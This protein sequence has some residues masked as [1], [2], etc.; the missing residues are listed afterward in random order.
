MKWGNVLSYFDKFDK[1]DEIRK[2]IISALKT[3][4]YLSSK[5]MSDSEA[6]KRY[7]TTLTRINK[8]YRKHFMKEILNQSKALHE[9]T[10]GFS[11]EEWKAHQNTFYS[12]AKIPRNIV[13]ISKV[14]FTARNN[15]SHDIDQNDNVDISGLTLLASAYAFLELARYKQ[16]QENKER[17]SK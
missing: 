15:S 11:E 16:D 10:E 12:V 5:G 1:C 9:N 2:T 7:F 17:N 3:S 14:I 8:Y 13:E 4:S 6:E